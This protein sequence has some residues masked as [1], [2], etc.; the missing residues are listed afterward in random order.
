MERLVLTGMIVVAFIVVGAVLA[1]ALAPYLD[2]LHSIHL[3]V[4][5]R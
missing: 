2:Q 5:Q 1:M 3:T 4:P